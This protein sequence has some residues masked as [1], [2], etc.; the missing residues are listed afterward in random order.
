VALPPLPPAQQ[1]SGSTLRS[2]LG[3]VPLQCTRFTG[4]RLPHTLAVGA[5]PTACA[6]TLNLTS[7]GVV[8][9]VRASP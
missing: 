3:G 7:T 4:T 8:M 1:Q 6:P 2:L 9:L 5:F